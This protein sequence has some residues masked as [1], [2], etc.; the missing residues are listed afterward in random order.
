[1]I[2]ALALAALFTGIHHA[3]LIGQDFSRMGWTSAAH[4]V[5]SM[6]TVNLFAVL[7]TA[8]T[9]Y[10]YRATVNSFGVMLLFGFFPRFMVRI[11]HT[12]QLSRRECIWLYAAPL[13]ARV[14]I[15]SVCLLIWFGTRTMNGFLPQ[16]ALMVGILGAASLLLAANPLMKSS[17]SQ[18]LGA[19]LN[20]PQLRQ[21]AYLALVNKL[22]GDVYRKADNN[23]LAVYAL[24]SSLF[25]MATLAV[26]I[27]F[28][29]NLLKLHLGGAGIFLVVLV[30]MT[31]LLRLTAKIKQVAAA[32]E[33]TAQ[34]DRWKNRALPNVE[35]LSAETESKSSPMTPV[36]WLIVGTI[37]AGLFVP[38]HY[39]PG[40]TFVLLPN[41]K[42]E[43]TT[44]N[45]AII[46]KV[47]FDGGEFITK[48]TVVAELSSVDYQGQMKIY[49]A[50]VNEQQAIV[51]DLRARP[52]PEE[53]QLARRA[54]QVQEQ[55]GYFSGQKINRLE[56]LY[57]ENTISLEEFEDQR[58][59]FE[60]DAAQIK[61]YRAK[62][63]LVKAEVTKQEIAAAEAK[64][65]S[66]REERDYYQEKINQ[67]MITMP[68]DG[69]LEGVNL[70]QK[71]GHYLNKGEL[72]AVAQN[73]SQVFAEIEVPQPDIGYIKKSSNIRVRPLSY[74]DTDFNGMVMAIDAGVTE[75][76]SGK[77]VKVLTVLDNKDDLLKSGMTGYAKI[78]ADNMPIAKVLT[79]AL[80]RFFEVE[81]WSWLP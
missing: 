48:G 15:A 21:K 29:G 71:V 10:S 53:L 33:R 8:L 20:E 46:S 61:E 52:K 14:G 81:V 79:K 16:L 44:E 24:A 62:L 41:Q 37:A 80:V 39:E 17:G 2:P 65:Q 56:T 50:K 34:F 19:V 9:A 70:R 40:G 67:S 72:F 77:V 64:L 59:E 13:L 23:V 12:K 63:E 5:T 31:L 69:R 76:D 6:F 3:N 60:V 32:Y 57:K 7:V 55:R 38:Y 68:F 28:F 22:R 66:Y 4:V 47:H 35:T 78:S 27:L 42:S 11:G 49:V 54:L 45:S 43:L 51:E 36:Q 30:L 1:M 26:F 74:S 25:I 58:K 18:L 73:T 75:K